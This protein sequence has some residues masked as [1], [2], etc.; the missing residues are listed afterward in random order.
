M[1][2]SGIKLYSGLS[3][4]GNARRVIR[5][6]RLARGRTCRQYKLDLLCRVL[7]LLSLTGNKSQSSPL[8]VASDN[9]R[10]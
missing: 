5:C 8:I 6:K 1:A 7:R 3:V 4:G 9:V 10:C 2:V